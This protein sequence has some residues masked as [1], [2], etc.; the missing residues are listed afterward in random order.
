[1][2]YDNYGCKVVLH[3]K[4]TDTYG[5]FCSFYKEKERESSFPAEPETPKCVHL[6]YGTCTSKEACKKAYMEHLSQ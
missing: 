6:E 2:I 3:F 5:E 4:C 1:M